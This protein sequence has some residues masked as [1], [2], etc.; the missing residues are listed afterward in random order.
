MSGGVESSEGMRCGEQFL[1]SLATLFDGCDC[2]YPAFQPFYS[3]FSMDKSALRSYLTCYS[4][5]TGG[6]WLL[7]DAPS[8]EVA[9]RAYPDLI[10]FPTH[11]DWMND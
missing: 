11:P 2:G 5:G 7:L 6:V 4:Y 3:M 10:V 8:H 9:Q 1:A